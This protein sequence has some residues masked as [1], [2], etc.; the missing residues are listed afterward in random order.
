MK[1]VIQF[2]VDAS[3]IW[4]KFSESNSFILMRSF[5]EVRQVGLKYGLLGGNFTSGIFTIF[6]SSVLILVLFVTLEK[7]VSK[8]SVC[9]Q[10]FCQFLHF[11]LSHLMI[12][13]ARFFLKHIRTVKF[14]ACITLDCVTTLPICCLR[15]LYVYLQVW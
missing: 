11:Y 12:S 3:H 9:T 8:I 7:R 13:C 14:N 6:R 4:T 1:N 2:Y 10:F 15:L 5:I